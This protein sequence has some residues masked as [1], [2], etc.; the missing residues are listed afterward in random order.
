MTP[1]TRGLLVGACI[2]VVVGVALIRERN[3][4][5]SPRVVFRSVVSICHDSWPNNIAMARVFKAVDDTGQ[6]AIAQ[7]PTQWIG[8][9]G[10]VIATFAPLPVTIRGRL[11][12]ETLFDA[13]GEAASNSSD[14]F[15][16][17][18]ALRIRSLDVSSR[19]HKASSDYRWF[20]FHSSDSESVCTW[21]P[22][23]IEN[24]VK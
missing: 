19:F 8:S 24:V 17:F 1:V 10:G 18:V 20:E 11:G 9:S 7:T 4:T 14:R 15:G 12:P 13:N 21:L 22:E 23:D 5:A 3:L 16:R 6:G 2:C